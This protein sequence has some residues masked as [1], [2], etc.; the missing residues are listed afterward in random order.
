MSS[1][2]E[3]SKWYMQACSDTNAENV[4]VVVQSNEMK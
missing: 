4:A 2:K 3:G 1:K